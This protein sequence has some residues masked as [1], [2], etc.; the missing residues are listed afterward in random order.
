MNIIQGDFSL[1]FSN[2]SLTRLAPTPTKSST[3][4]EAAIEIKGTPDSPA[5]AFAS[6]VFPVPGGPINKTPFGTFAPR[7]KNFRFF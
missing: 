5:I 7:A 6:N 2:K 1:A 4:S 3:N